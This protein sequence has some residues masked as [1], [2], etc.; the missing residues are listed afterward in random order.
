[1]G[2][3]HAHICSMILLSLTMR[4]RPREWTGSGLSD[5]SWTARTEMSTTDAI[6]SSGILENIMSSLD[7]SACAVSMD[8]AKVR[9]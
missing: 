9:R 5:I 8:S 3:R 2:K 6:A 7:Y 4:D 1:M